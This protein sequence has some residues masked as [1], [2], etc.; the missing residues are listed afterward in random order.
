MRHWFDQ[1][2][3]CK[4]VFEDMK[5][6]SNYIYFMYT[7]NSSNL[8]GSLVGLYFTTIKNHGFKVCQRQA[9]VGFIKSG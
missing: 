9:R 4:I 5:E 6:F 7:Y 3:V 8:N 2:I 1:Q